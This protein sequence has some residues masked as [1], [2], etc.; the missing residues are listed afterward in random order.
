MKPR[1]SVY[2]VPLSLALLVVLMTPTLFGQTTRSK[3][4]VFYDDPATQRFHQQTAIDALN[5]IDELGAANNFDVDKTFDKS[6]FTDA[7]LR[8][9]DAVIFLMPENQ[10]F[11]N[12]AQKLAL[13][14][15]VKGGGGFVGIHGAMYMEK[16]SF[17]NPEQ[18]Q[19]LWQWY[20]QVIGANPNSDGPYQPNRLIPITVTDRT[21][22]STQGLPTTWQQNDEWYSLQ[23]TTPPLNR[24]AIKVLATVDG[25]TNNI[26]GTIGDDHPVTWYQINNTTVGQGRSWFTAMGHYPANWTQ[27]TFRNH[28]LGGILWAAGVTAQPSPSASPSASPST[29]PSPSASPS[30]SPSPGAET[31]YLPLITR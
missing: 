16:P 11:T 20:R 6:V 4:L 12:A 15:Y 1:S 10:K 30:A 17:S 24:N 23:Y 2:L 27:S 21:H 18:N 25:D 14:N 19:N 13:E 28:V 8:Q 7:N 5:A 31:E 9:Y 3:V 29:T 22:P 26:G